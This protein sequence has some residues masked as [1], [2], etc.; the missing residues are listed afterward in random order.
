MGPKQFGVIGDF[1]HGPD[2][3]TGGF[4]GVPLFDGNGG[5]NAFD[6]VR[7]GFIHAVEELAGVR[8]ERFDVPALAF[9]KEGFKGQGTFARPAQAGDDHQL[10]Q[11]QVEVNILQVVLP[12]ATKADAGWRRREHEATVIRGPMVS[13]AARLFS[14]LRPLIFGY[15]N[16]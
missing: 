4:D 5:R 9:G 1:S 10:A 7:L 11:R 8:G 2:C 6:A 14:P 15:F 13:I 3:G 16:A 12:H